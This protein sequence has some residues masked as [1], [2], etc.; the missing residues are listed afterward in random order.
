MLEQVF[1]TELK[2]SGI[3]A[4]G[5]DLAERRSQLRQARSRRSERIIEL[6]VVEGVEELGTED[7]GLSLRK[8]GGLNDGNVPVELTGAE[9]N[10]NA[11]VAEACSVAIDTAGRSRANCRGIKV[12][13][14]T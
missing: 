8:L 12:A 6:R 10:A 7:Q 1:H 11:R 13:G 9:N 4:G 2:N 3:H 5:G 14:A